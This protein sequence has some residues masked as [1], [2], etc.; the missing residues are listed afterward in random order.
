MPSSLISS[1]VRKFGEHLILRHL[2]AAQVHAASA[3]TPPPEHQVG[4]DVGVL[5][6]VSGALDAAAST[7]SSLETRSKPFLA[8]LNTDD[9][10]NQAVNS[11]FRWH[12]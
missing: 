5:G 6:D 7:C 4:T 9:L 12:L 8:L 2:P 3:R 11:P 10:I 1:I